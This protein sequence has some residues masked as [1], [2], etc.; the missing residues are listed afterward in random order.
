MTIE[1]PKAISDYF[2]ADRG[3]DPEAVAQCFAE[4]AVVKDEGHTYTGSDAIRQWK[5]HASAKY[6]YTVDPFS[7]VAE[8][9]RTVVTSHLAGDFPG[10]PTDLRYVFLLA[11]ET[12]A[13]L[14]I[15]P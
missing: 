3:K 15:L 10:S 8:G 13:E 14:E 11:D 12:I 7:I 2:E 9:E 6:T 1:L 4:N 5:A